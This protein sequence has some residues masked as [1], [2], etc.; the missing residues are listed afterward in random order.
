M[1]QKNF[2]QVLVDIRNCYKSYTLND[3]DRS[4]TTS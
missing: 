2:N 3:I 4:A 1:F